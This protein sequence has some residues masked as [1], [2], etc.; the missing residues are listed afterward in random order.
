[1]QSAPGK[2]RTFDNR[3]RRPVLYPAELRARTRRTFYRTTVGSVN[4]ISSDLVDSFSPLAFATLDH[5]GH[6]HPGPNHDT[7][8]RGRAESVANKAGKRP[9]SDSLS[10]LARRLLDGRG[11]FEHLLPPSLC[12]LRSL[13]FADL[14]SLSL[15]GPCSSCGGSLPSASRS[16]RGRVQRASTCFFRASASNSHAP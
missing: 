9:R 5:S 3:F 1:M 8:A 16:S 14:S 4:T 15:R 2:I 11:S 10:S 12:L 7:D 13:A 6:R